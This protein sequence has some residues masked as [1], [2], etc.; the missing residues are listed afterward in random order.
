[1]TI[2]R[3]SLFVFFAVLFSTDVFS[4]VLIPNVVTEAGRLLLIVIM[5]VTIMQ[6]KKEDSFSLIKRH[7]DK[8]VNY[9]IGIVLFS[10]VP[11]Y[12]FHGQNFYISVWVARP[13]FFWLLYKYLHIKKYSPKLILNEMFKVGFLWGVVVIVQ[14]RLYPAIYFNQSRDNTDEFLEFFAQTRGVIRLSIAGFFVGFFVAL[15][16]LSQLLDR[17]KFMKMV[18]LIAI[19]IGV[20]FTGSR[21]Y[22]GVLLFAIILTIFYSR[23]S[24][25]K[26]NIS[27]IFIL[28]ISIVLIVIIKYDYITGLINVSSDDLSAGDSY[29]RFIEIHFYL[30]EFWPNWLTVVIGNGW[31]HSSSPYG[32]EIYTLWMKQHYFREDVGIVGGFSKFGILYVFV[33]FKI[34]YKSVFKVKLPKS[35][36]YIRYFF[37]LTFLLYFAAQDWFSYLSSVPVFAIALYL[38]DCYNLEYTENQKAAVR[39]K[40][41]DLK[42]ISNS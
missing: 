13:I 24:A 35:R 5:I 27:K 3:G 8:E 29:I 36:V 42:A 32:K 23:N 7:F 2:K 33:V 22:L 12:L 10:S 16:T 14:Q 26:R 30:L 38:I 37:V 39:V 40:E 20:F 9:L 34:I 11:A 28:L 15:E 19:I 17:V 31:E 25:G 6:T 21:Q 18:A 41:M 4:T 1:M